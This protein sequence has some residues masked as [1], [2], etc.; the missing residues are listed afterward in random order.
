MLVANK[1]EGAKNR[2]NIEYPCE[3]NLTNNLVEISHKDTN[4]EL[5]WCISCY[6]QHRACEIRVL[7]WSNPSC[8]ITLRK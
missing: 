2:L 4:H 5:T 1:K 8:V 6:S 7:I 3:Y